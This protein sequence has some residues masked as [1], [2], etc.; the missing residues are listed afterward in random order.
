MKT[1]TCFLLCFFM[2]ITGTHLSAQKSDKKVTITGKVL[3]ENSSPITNAIVMIDGQKTNSITDASGAY[4]VK[5]SPNALRIGV[6]TFSNGIFEEDIAGRTLIDFNLTTKAAQPNDQRDYSLQ[7][8]SENAAEDNMVNTGYNKI[9]KKNLTT[10]ISKVDADKPTRTYTSIY[11][12][13]RE[14]PGVVVRGRSVNIQDS[15][16]LMGPVPPLVVVDGVPMGNTEYFNI[17]SIM[18]SEVKSIEVLKSTSAA[19]YG[20]RGFGGVILITRK[21]IEPSE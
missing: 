8:K 13:L 15:K 18:P 20:S 17:E 11:D 6:F 7:G 1:M 4:K 19:I 5:V 10:E 9:D 14:V 3:D 21:T 12:M 16:N 2:G